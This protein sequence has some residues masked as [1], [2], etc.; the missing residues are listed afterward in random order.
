MFYSN[1]LELLACLAALTSSELL[2]CVQG[3]DMSIPTCS[4]EKS[5]LTRTEF[6]ERS[7]FNFFCKQAAANSMHEAPGSRWVWNTWQQALLWL[8]AYDALR[9][10]ACDAQLASYM[11][12]TPSC[13]GPASR[14]LQWVSDRKFN[15]C[16]LN[17]AWSTHV[18]QAEHW[19]QESW[20]LCEQ[21]Y[22]YRFK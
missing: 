13:R 14:P 2:S 18:R 11:Q 19:Q 5:P 17:F 7:K 1:F 15:S 9:V 4:S 12:R 22:R 10:T 3:A 8:I 16:S 20:K 21:W 6:L